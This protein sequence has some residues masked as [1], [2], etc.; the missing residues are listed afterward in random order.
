M[1]TWWIILSILG[2]LFSLAGALL[3]WEWFMTH[4]KAAVFVRLLG[5]GGARLLYAFLG[6]SLVA[7]GLAGAFEL[8]P[9]R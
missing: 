8:I 2:G 4:H 7:L 6:L 3:D 5:R 1:P 9:P